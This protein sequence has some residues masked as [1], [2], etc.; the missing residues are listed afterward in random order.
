M[1]E[2]DFYREKP[3]EPK[4]EPEPPV[5]EEKG[6]PIFRREEKGISGRG[7]APGKKEIT[8]SKAA[9]PEEKKLPPYFKKKDLKMW[10]EK[11]PEAFA[12]S[13]GMKREKRIQIPDQMEA[14]L[15]KY[16]SNVGETY[17]IKPREMDKTLKVLKYQEHYGKTKDEKGSWRTLK[18][19]E[20]K[21]ARQT[22]KLLEGYL[23][24]W[25]TKK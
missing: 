9:T 17:N 19:N 22:R 14:I 24:D 13:G 21:E 20:I 15:K 6:E 16:R 25:K 4:S 3:S 2:E 23:K 1:A 8:P 12:L 10:L 7:E 18:P 5:Q 11:D